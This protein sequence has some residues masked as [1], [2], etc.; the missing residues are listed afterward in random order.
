MS[1][2]YLW[3]KQG[4][5][6]PEVVRLEE[7][8]GTLREP[9]QPLRA[10]PPRPS[11][12]RRWLAVAASLVA[13]STVGAWAVRERQKP[14][15]E[16]AVLSG[17]PTVHAGLMRPAGTVA[18]GDAVETDQKSSARLSVD[19]VGE[20]RLAPNSRLRLVETR[21]GEH[22]FA[23]AQG[24]VEAFIW[25]PP[26][27]FFVQTPSATAVDLGCVYTLETA[28]D[29]ISEVMVRVG[30]VALEGGGRES[31]IPSGARCRTM[32]RFGPG[33]PRY[34]DAPASLVTALDQ[35]EQT[36]AEPALAAAL[37]SARARDS[38][39]LWHLLCRVSGEQRGRVWE[40]MSA[41]KQMPA[42]VSASA[43]QAGDR[44]ALDAVWESLGL[45]EAAWWRTWR[46][47]VAPR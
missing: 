16:V 37:A 27:Q 14:T 6:D 40:R 5:P 30:W 17:T 20:V 39:S 10:L 4:V 41:L 43:V 44:A 46:Q 9:Q 24:R 23:L 38:M 11:P 32:P 15:W 1:G 8:L 13:V 34:Q 2:D 35:W 31:F 47:Q 33:V 25:A 26:G 3:D 28:A 45:G 19:S 18:S 22:R 21:P 42:A 36:R 12:V 29:G 7:L